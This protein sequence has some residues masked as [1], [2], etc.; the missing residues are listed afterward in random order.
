MFHKI[1]A[2]LQQGMHPF[3]ML[4]A[5]LVGV[6]LLTSV[7]GIWHH[8]YELSQ[9]VD[10]SVETSEAPAE[11]RTT[12]S[13]DVPTLHVAPTS[14][15]PAANQNRASARTP[16]PAETSL[17]P[18]ASA[19]QATP[20]PAASPTPQPAT[21]ATI[22]V[23]LYVND[24]HRGDVSLLATSNQCDVL[25]KALQ[26]GVISSL[27]MRYSSQYKTYAVYVIEG[28]GDSASI[29][30]TYS[31]NGKSPPYGCSGTKVAAGDI[32]NWKYVKQ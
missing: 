30:W 23:S 10:M 14:T 25:Q 5:G 32:V 7:A 1:R 8:H 9:Q 15:E 29:W 3:A 20:A 2:K 18:A 11:L 16:N 12:Q 22:T 4:T 17:Q 24:Q 31:V 13:Y 21:P 6:L 28:Q 26:S 27:D 19:P